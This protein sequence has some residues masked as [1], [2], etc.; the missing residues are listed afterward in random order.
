MRA[1][2]SKESSLVKATCTAARFQ[3]PIMLP[4]QSSENCVWSAVRVAQSK[5]WAARGRAKAPGRGPLDIAHGIPTFIGDDIA[6]QRDLARA[7]LAIFTTFP[8]YQRMFRASGFAEEA[9][10]QSRAPAVPR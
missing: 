7:N 5:K 6:V 3:I 2:W 4:A 9:M 10:R 1:F 8:F